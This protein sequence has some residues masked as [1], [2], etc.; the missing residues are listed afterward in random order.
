LEEAA[1][2]YRK[3]IDLF[4]AH[5]PARR[6][7]VQQLQR[8]EQMLALEK[9]LVLILR[10]EAQPA[11]AAEQLGLAELCAIQKRYAAAA[12]F[13]GDAFAAQPKLADDLDS[14]NR[15]NAACVAALAGCGQGKDAGPIDAQERTRLRRRALAWLRADLARYAQLVEH[16]RS[17]AGGVVQQWL[18]HWQHDTDFTGVRDAAALAKLPDAERAGW[19]KLWAE[20]DVLL[21][22]CTDSGK[23]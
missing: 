13:F 18:R 3:A 7:C 6:W 16:R 8:C 2:E 10:A 1:A 22:K 14:R 9:K 19:Q 20:V 5:D 23:K 12:R 21:K 4:P 15:Y 17:Q 11:D